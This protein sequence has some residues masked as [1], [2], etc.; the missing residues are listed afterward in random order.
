MNRTNI[1]K[2]EKEL[3][4]SE[5]HTAVNLSFSLSQTDFHFYSISSWSSL[6]SFCLSTLSFFLF[7]LRYYLN[8][9]F[10]HF[11][12]YLSP[13]AGQ[14]SGCSHSLHKKSLTAHSHSHSTGKVTD[15]C[16]LNTI[17]ALFRGRLS[18]DRKWEKSLKGNKSSLSINNCGHGLAQKS[19]TAVGLVYTNTID[20]TTNQHRRTI[21]F[22]ST[23]EW[24]CH[25]QLSYL[26]RQHVTASLEMDCLNTSDDTQ[27]FCLCR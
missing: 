6:I 15:K 16:K 5:L 19:K 2:C 22:T 26:P 20:I 7:P 3:K 27:K 21:Q 11:F 4:K 1:S 25:R 13:S 12:R 8:S 10:S 23:F 9:L 24:L 17:P 14:V 18:A